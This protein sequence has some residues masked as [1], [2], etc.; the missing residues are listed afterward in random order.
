M[1]YWKEQQLKTSKRH[2]EERAEKAKAVAAAKARRAEYLMHLRQGA[3]SIHKSIAEFLL[4]R[5]GWD[6][7]ANPDQKCDMFLASWCARGIEWAALGAKGSAHASQ[8]VLT[9]YYRG[10]QLLCY[11]DSCAMNLQ[12]SGSDG[13]ASTYLD[14]GGVVVVVVLLLLLPP[15]PPHLH[16][17][18][19]GVQQPFAARFAHPIRIALDG[20]TRQLICFRLV[21]FLHS[22]TRIT[23]HG[24]TWMWTSPR[25]CL[26]LLFSSLTRRRGL[27]GAPPLCLA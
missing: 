13:H 18:P 22:M 5:G 3:I 8:R 12:V 10:Y 4:L 15:P 11:K 1:A 24:R 21:A 23:A 20:I 17:L 26:R 27:T 19:P 2:E 16:S 6:K 14:C 9:N 7:T 25:S